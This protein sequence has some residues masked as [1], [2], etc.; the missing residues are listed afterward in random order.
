MKAIP[1][2]RPAGKGVYFLCWT[3]GRLKAAEAGTGTV[4]IIRGRKKKYNTAVQ[5]QLW[6][7]GAK[8]KGR[9]EAGSWARNTNRFRPQSKIA[10]VKNHIKR[11]LASWMAG[12]M[13]RRLPSNTRVLD[14]PRTAPLITPQL[15]KRHPAPRPVPP[16]GPGAQR[17]G[18]QVLGRQQVGALPFPQ[19]CSL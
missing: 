10:V 15:R 17:T 4:I 18:H 11:H 9:R 12:D 5:T 6:E 19:G 13:K 8:L 1:L 16:R 2:I 3:L 14:A 7:W